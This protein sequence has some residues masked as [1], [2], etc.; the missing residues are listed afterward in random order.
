M[1]R[2]Q[3]F[4]SVFQINVT[5]PGMVKMTD[6]FSKPELDREQFD[7]RGRGKRI[8]MMIHNAV[9]AGN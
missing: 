5:L 2:K 9:F 3:K 6:A 8:R 7:G 1:N 4:R